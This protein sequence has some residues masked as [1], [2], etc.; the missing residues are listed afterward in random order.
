MRRF[1]SI[2]LVLLVVVVLAAAV[3]WLA[4]VP[5]AERLLAERLTHY[6]YPQAQFTIAGIGWS[7]GVVTRIT[8][9][10]EAGPRAQ[11]VTV[12]YN[13]L[14]LVAGDVRHVTV[15][16]AGL[17]AQVDL[18]TRT[19]AA[20]GA[21]AARAERGPDRVVAM[22][23]GM[24]NV[25]VDDAR[26]EVLGLRGPWQ[27]R[28]HADLQQPER[29]DAGPTAEIDGSIQ[30]E[31]LHVK[32]RFRGRLDGGAANLYLTLTEDDGFA[33]DLATFAAPP[34]D[35]ARANVEYS[36]T[37]PSD[38]D[39]P[40]AL[41]PGPRPAA[42]TVRLSG[43]AR[44]RLESLTRP[45]GLR[46]AFARL[47]AGEWSAD[48]RLVAEG[49]GFTARFSGLDLEAAGT[50]TPRRDGVT[51]A[52]DGSGGMAVAR[53]HEALWSRL[54]PP[55]A[56]VPYVAGPMRVTWEAGEVV[57]LRV[58]PAADDIGPVIEIAPRLAVRW[59]DLD[60]RATLAADARAELA[61][62]MTVERL[63][64]SDLAAELRDAALPRAH[65][66][67]ARLSGA[68]DGLP[69]A[70]EGDLVL[71][72]DAPAVDLDPVALRGVSARVPLAVSRRGDTIRI[73]VKP[74]GSLRAEGWSAGAGIEP[75]GGLAASLTGGHLDLGGARPWA[76]T[77]TP[78]PVALALARAGADGLALEMDSG[79][80]RATG[81]LADGRPLERV[82]VSGLSL[83][84]PR[85]DLRAAG[86]SATIRPGAGEGFAEFTAERVAYSPLAPFAVRGRID[87]SARGFALDARGTGAG[88]VPVTLAGRSDA[89]ART[90]RL[91]ID[92]PAFRFE[93]GALQPG[94]LVPALGML[95]GARGG[96]EA[97]ATLIWSDAGIDGDARLA[98]DALSFRAGIASVEGLAG[99]VVLSDLVPPRAERRQ[100]IRIAR[101]GIGVPLTDVSVR[102]GLGWRPARGTVVDVVEARASV[103]GGAALVRDW[104][105][106]PGGQLHPVGVDVEDVDLAQ[107]LRQIEVGALS[108]TGR[109][110][111]RVPMTL[112]DGELAVRDARLRADSGRVQL[113]SERAGEILTERGAAEERI[114]H[115]LRDFAYDT[116][117]LSV[118]RE[119]RGETRL[120]IHM[121]G[122]SPEVTGSDPL[123]FDIALAG[124]FMPLL[125]QLAEGGALGDDLVER[126]LDLRAV[127]ER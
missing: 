31:R 63:A 76:A 71:A 88:G 126:S 29:Q 27:V 1:L 122:R 54:S 62:P 35:E 7:E 17:R 51:I 110:S 2:L 34:W 26:I 20:P 47:A 23:A 73:G 32:G 38:A 112:L 97:G 125:R 91:R 121:R 5:I 83:V 86:V 103:L 40:W 119:P 127:E 15:T 99:E 59:P 96:A 48:Y 14:R 72:L 3:A 4:R 58:P 120:G 81:R 98:L 77:L 61:G 10:P 82:Q 90:G 30:N 64:L 106:D 53:V 24:P 13:P 87:R 25:R 46:A 65:I 12:S 39:L 109:V 50:L 84:L 94:D 44:G 102:F 43:S 124:D 114:A 16:V 68:L 41:L 107:L 113:R 21:E 67:R 70:P 105:F 36:V 49:L 117:E 19:G 89:R 57:G 111:G 108:G 104:S 123:D 74:G 95:E 79:R 75:R 28:L 101:V 78:E 115:A 18:Q 11:R 116:L 37:M 33:V 92:V 56:L 8:L 9:D 6:G 93:P 45:A 60:G 22:L 42:G 100:E 118:A 80:V 55:R 66:R 69:A 52:S 85:R